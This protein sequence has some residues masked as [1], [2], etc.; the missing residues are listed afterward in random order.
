MPPPPPR[1][2]FA[3]RV[4]LVCAVLALICATPVVWVVVRYAPTLPGLL[5]PSGAAGVGVTP[6]GPRSPRPGDPPSVYAAWMRAQIDTALHTQGAA[7]RSGDEDGFLAVGEPGNAEVRTELGRRY[8]SLRGLQVTVWEPRVAES[9]TQETG[10]DDPAEWRARLSLR[11]CFVVPGCEADD[12][13]VESRWVQRNGRAY[14]VRL[15][16][17]GADQ[18]GPRP[19]EVADLRVAVGKRAVVATT[20]DYSARLPSLLGEADRAATVADRFAVGPVPDRYH[21]FFAGGTE[22]KR[23]YNGNRPEWAAGYAVPTSDRRIDVVLNAAEVPSGF[24]DDIMRHE[25]SHAAS[26]RGSRHQSAAWWLVEGLAE[27]AELYGRAPTQHDAVAAGAVRRFIASGKW[28]GGVAVSEPVASAAL[29]EAGARYG[30]AFLAV[31][32]LSERYG[33]VKL[34]AFFKAVVH[35]GK[36]PEVAAPEALGAPWTDVHA[37]CV[38]YVRRIGA[39]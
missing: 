6:G 25:L 1:R 10:V 22:W 35:E 14:L 21:M 13:R 28:D 7:L 3:L 33:E 23:W 4:L 29:Q 12:L 36:T 5:A 37:D 34:L 26:L 9:P 27:Q 32:R 11:H 18:N 31:R 2:R 15:D 30:I 20:S 24:V 16:A 17:S 8:R 38:S 19:W 39:G